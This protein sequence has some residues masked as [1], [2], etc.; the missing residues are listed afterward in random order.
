[1]SH[2]KAF[3][4]LLRDFDT[5]LQDLATSRC[6]IDMGRMLVQRAARKIDDEG[7]RAARKELAMCKVGFACCSAFVCYSTSS[8]VS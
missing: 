5:I 6:E 1:M 7:S 4:R 3:G 8:L 2:R